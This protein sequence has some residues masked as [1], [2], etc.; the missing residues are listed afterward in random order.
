MAIATQ[1][2]LNGI[3]AGAVYA[4]VASGFSLIYSVTKF[5]HLAHGAV[6]ALGAYLLYTFAVNAGLNFWLAI[7]LTLICTSFSGVLIDWLVY[8][9]LRKR[10]A[11]GAVLLIAS[12]AVLIFVNALILALWGAD[13]KTISTRNPVFDFVGARITRSE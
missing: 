2:I 6:L 8:R 13:V 7:L 9:P 4:L 1:L 5:M 11:S 3:I 12:I 10:K